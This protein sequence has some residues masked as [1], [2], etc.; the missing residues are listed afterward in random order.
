[1]Q[2][3]GV[4]TKAC[5]PCTLKGRKQDQVLKVTEAYVSSMRP[6]LLKQKQTKQKANGR[7]G[8]RER[9]RE[10][11]LGEERQANLGSVLV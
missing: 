6:C 3:P 10:V 11:V 1:M 4:V 9:G 8:G 7:E 2:K 5:N